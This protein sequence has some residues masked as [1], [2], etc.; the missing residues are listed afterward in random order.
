[1]L[2]FL[3]FVKFRELRVRLDELVDLAPD[4]VSLILLCR[5]TEHAPHLI[6]AKRCKVVTK[7]ARD[8]RFTVLSAYLY[9]GFTVP[10]DIRP[11]FSPS[12]DVA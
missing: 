2:V 12:K 8:E 10:P 9:V 5:G 3:Y 6:A 7:F 4:N 11:L 1:M